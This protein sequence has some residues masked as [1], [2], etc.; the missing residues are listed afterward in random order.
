MF[1]IVKILEEKH[2]TNTREMDKAIVMC[3]S[4]GEQQVTLLQNAQKSNREKRP[5]CQLCIK[6]THH[7]MTNSRIWRIWKGMVSRC[8]KKYEPSYKHYGGR[9][10]RVSSKWADFK[11]FY[12]DMGPS[13]RD[14]LQIDRIDVNGDYEKGNCRWVTPMVQQSNKRSS[15]VVSYQGEDLHLAEYCRR[16]G[17]SRGAITPRLDNGM[18]GDEAAEDWKMSK[19]PKGRKSRRYTT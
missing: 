5:N 8:M 3:L 17:C 12:K 1:E 6:T 19:Y 15:R 9:G 7:N 14:D 11:E 10:I 16:V 4:C 13:Y 2:V 18:S